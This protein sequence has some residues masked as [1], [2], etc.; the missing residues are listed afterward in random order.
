MGKLLGNWFLMLSEL[1][2]FFIFR[3]FFFLLAA[4]PLVISR[5]VLFNL[6]VNVLA[7]IATAHQFMGQVFHNLSFFVVSILQGRRNGLVS[8]II[9]LHCEFVSDH[10]LHFVIAVVRVHWFNLNFFLRHSFLLLLFFRGLILIV[11]SLIHYFIALV[12]A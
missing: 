10:R 5:Q 7:W 12:T 6:V 4:S 1:I 8:G 2:L 3:L 9:Y 11:V